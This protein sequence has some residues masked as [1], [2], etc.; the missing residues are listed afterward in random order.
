MF[1]G[2]RGYGARGDI[3][4]DD[5]SLKDGACP[6][7]GSCDFETDLCGFTQRRD[8]TFDW[9]RKSGA[10]PTQN[11]GPSTDHTLGTTTGM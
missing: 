10:T 11:T 1:E 7:A 5:V 2:V 3:G 6:G 4:I 9:L 8:D